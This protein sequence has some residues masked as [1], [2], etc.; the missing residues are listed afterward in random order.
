M[1]ELWVDH[2]SFSQLTTVQDC[3]YQY[4]LLKMAKVEPVQN[5][6]AQAGILAHKLLA[7]WAKGVMTAADLPLQWTAQFPIEVTAELPH[8]LAAK[9]YA[10]KLYESI[11]YY[12]EN[13]KGFPGYEVIGVEKDFS[14]SLAGEHFVGVIDLILC[15]KETGGLVLVDHKSSSLSSF[16]KKKDEMYRQLL[17]YSKFCADQF[18]FFPEKL[19]FNLFKE[20]IIDER[21]FDPEDYRA[22][23]IWAEGIIND[24]KTREITDWFETKPE[25]FMCTN[26]CSCRNECIYGKPENHK[27]KDERNGNKQIP[28]IA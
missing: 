28:A 5:T 18:G 19:C 7:N 6:F 1:S 4:Y 9:G 26:L 2:L 24:M 13:F 17:L 3:P 20:N 22:A 12:F 21:L 23:R 10:T 11:L 25:F 15:N 8:F 14:S 27:R 16:R